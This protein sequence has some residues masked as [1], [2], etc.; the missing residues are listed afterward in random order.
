[1]LDGGRDECKGN[2][3]G[4]DRLENP[5]LFFCAGKFRNG[6]IIVLISR[7]FIRNAERQRRIACGSGRYGISSVPCVIN[8]KFFG[9]FGLGT[10]CYHVAVISSAVVGKN[11]GA[12]FTLRVKEICT[13]RKSLDVNILSL[14]AVLFAK[15]SGAESVI[16][17]IVSVYVKAV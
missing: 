15:V 5:L 12:V 17:H 2:S 7:C 9:L 3:L 4:L 1:M 8:D 11:I 14:A 16:C 6:E 13:V 10:F